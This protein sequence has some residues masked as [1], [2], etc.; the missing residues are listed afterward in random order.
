MEF[1]VLQNM[2]EEQKK[3]FEKHKDNYPFPVVEFINELGIR[4]FADDLE[5][6]N[7]GYIKKDSSGQVSIVINQ[8]HSVK[9]NRFTLAHELGHFFN[10]NEYLT[11]QSMIEDSFKLNRSKEGLP[12][13]REIEANKFAAELLMPKDKFIE[14]YRNSASI[15]NVADFFKV[16]VDAAKMR[17]HILLGILPK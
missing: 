5:D 2:T 13:K 8:N 17:A 9:R 10:D 15:D 4:T 14:V 11:K 6:H 12:E 16:S 7:S 3:I 1:D